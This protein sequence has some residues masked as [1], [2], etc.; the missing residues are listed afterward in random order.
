MQKHG[1]AC[2]LTQHTD[3]LKR[4]RLGPLTQKTDEKEIN[5]KRMMKNVIEP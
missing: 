4:L 1:S 5:K 3:A 2:R